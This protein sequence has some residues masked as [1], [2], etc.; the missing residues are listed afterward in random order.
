MFRP[1]VALLSKENLIHNIN[2]V[3]NRV[4]KSKIVAMIKANAYG[5]GI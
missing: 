5:H 3:K 1:A 2:V 4:G